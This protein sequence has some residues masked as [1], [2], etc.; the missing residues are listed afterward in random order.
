MLR[1][2]CGKCMRDLRGLHQN[3]PKR[4]TVEPR[5]PRFADHNFAHGTVPACLTGLS[6]AEEA[7]IAAACWAA[8]TRTRKRAFA[9]TRAWYQGVCARARDCARVTPPR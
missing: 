4:R 7:L 3:D 1:D 2:A 6:Y 8:P 9:H 5:Q